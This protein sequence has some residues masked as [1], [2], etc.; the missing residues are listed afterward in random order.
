MGGCG[1]K[2]FHQGTA[3]LSVLGSIYQGF[4]LGIFDPQRFFP[5]PRKGRPVGRFGRE[6]RRPFLWQKVPALADPL[7]GVLS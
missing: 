6:A 4:I 7:R 2:C 1:Q 3:G 5:H